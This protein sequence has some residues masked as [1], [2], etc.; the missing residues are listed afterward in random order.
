MELYENTSLWKNA[1]E[2]KDDGFDKSRNELVT[3]Y[4]NFRNRV[5]HLLQQIQKEIPS[6]T[7]HDI[8]HVDSLWRVAS[9]IAGFDFD[10][11]PAEAF[12]LG[13]AFLLHDAAHCRAAFPGGLL[14][15]QQTTEWQDSVAQR[16]IAL[17]TLIEGSEPFQAILFDTLRALH[18][19]HARKLPFA[20]WSSGVGGANLHLFPHEELCEAYGHIIG[21]IAESH[22]WHPHELES[23]AHKRP[24]SPVCLAP[25]NWTVDMLK[26][27]VLLRT[28]DAAHI[29]A[30]RA[31]RFLMAMNQPH[32]LSK[33]HWQFQA[34]LNQPKCDQERDELVFSGSPFPQEELSAWWLAFDAACLVNKEL[35]SADLLL[36]DNHR[37]QRLA[38]RSVTGTQSPEIFAKYVPA[39][40]WHPVDTSIKITDIKSIV[41]RFGGEKL[42]GSDPSAALRELL[43]NAVDSV[44]ACR[45][46]GGL[47][48][49]EG[50]IEVALE[51]APEGHWL[52]VTDTGIGMSRYV[53]TEVL[54]DFGRSLWRSTALRGEWSGLSVSGF[55]SIGQFGIGFFSV[56]M[57]GERVQVVTRRYDPK[58]GEAPQWL[59]DFAAGTNSRPTLRIPTINERI[60]RHG[61]R[62]SV[63]ISQEKLK[64]LCTKQNSWRNDSALISFD[65]VCSRI[66]PA[67]DLDLYVK[68]NAEAR[69]LAVRAND[70]LTLSSCDLFRRII[71][72]HLEHISTTQFGFWAH[73][74]EIRDSTGNIIGRC[75]VQPLY[76]GTNP[77]I[78]VVK[79]LFAGNVVGIAGIIMSKPQ[80]DLARKES[81]PAISLL[82]I[83]HWAENQK[84]LLLRHLK[85][86]AI[87]S[88]LLA[89]FGVGHTSLILGK[90]G[91]QT[92]SYEKFIL[93]AQEVNIIIVHSGDVNY[94]E[95]E[96]V[97]RRDFE[98]DFEVNEN[99]LELPHLQYPP[100][101]LNQFDDTTL[102]NKWS[103]ESALD[104]ALVEAWK[105]VEWNEGIEIV[106]SVYRTDITR[107]CRIASRQV[108]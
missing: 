90:F 92:V 60:K 19:K 70:W 3:A 16:G 61:T 59:L 20:Y 67:I 21:E 83:R 25:A 78:G 1:F 38:A 108:E 49:N 40:G 68:N 103:L 54:L 44:H 95:D 10:L 14:E 86:K 91:G 106:G 29:D 104:S 12:V 85:L 74:S 56:F 47:G 80:S 35:A 93:L 94:E 57:L 63:L 52:H 79:G 27:A 48:D 72:G 50:E 107:K 81:I 96:D 42:Y 46:L 17:E 71:P 30:L 82:E 87:N 105:N 4:Q 45:A 84:M 5:V 34:R 64:A 36:R 31:P 24:S 89:L 102:R 99:L 18:P 37:P 33:D 9:E 51:D 53:L 88:A 55:E 8:T 76:F 11:N 28:A 75:A 23:F 101:W 22:W 13:G 69:Q 73:L 65:Q 32:G 66:A 26:V 62:V 39:D 100:I 43:Q 7:L 6:L 97:L 98:S 58:E 2:P 15:L 77:G 41:E